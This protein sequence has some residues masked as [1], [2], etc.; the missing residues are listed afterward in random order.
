MFRKIILI[1]LLILPVLA[2]CDSSNPEEVAELPT[3]FIPPT[4]TPTNTATPT[5]TRTPSLTPT[6]TLT[7]TPSLTATPTLSSTPSHTPTHTPIPA[8]NT[9]SLTPTNTLTFTPVAT[10]TP[11]PTNTPAGPQILSFSASATA[12]NG[13]TPI[14]LS[15]QAIADI[16]IMEELNVQGSVIQ[17]WS[18]TPSGQLQV[19]VPNIGPQ[20]IYR[21][22]IQK[23]GMELTQSIPIQVTVTCPTPWFFGGVNAP[24]GAGCPAG[25]ASSIVGKLQLFERGLMFNLTLNAQNRVYG[26]NALNGRFMVY[27]SAWDGSTI[28]SIPCGTAPSG[29]FDPQ[30]VFN[31]AYH[32][33][34]GT[35]GLW[36]DATSGIGW[37]TGAANLAVNFTVQF[38]QNNTTFYIGIPGYGVV[39][40]IPGEAQTGTW[41]R[42]NIQ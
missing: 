18:I 27:Q 3:R 29:L 16:A 5:L 37:G 34:L 11:V 4:F 33:T 22:K 39:R 28:T 31:W 7:F 25:P 2:A 30:D 32:N 21:L 15:W 6:N 14:T 12:V 36:C 35:Q 38:E 24:P 1:I 17:T 40:I 9:P 41:T 8:T 13:G 20:V 19:T 23:G 10:A 26:L 42:L